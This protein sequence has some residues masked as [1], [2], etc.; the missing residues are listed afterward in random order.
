MA[1]MRK[2]KLQLSNPICSS[3][4]IN[5]G[6]STASTKYW[7]P[8]TIW[9]F[10]SELVLL[11]PN[12]DGLQLF[13]DFVRGCTRQLQKTKTS[14]MHGNDWF[15]LNAKLSII[16]FISWR[17]HILYIKFLIYIDWLI[18]W[19]VDWLVL[20]VDVVDYNMFQWKIGNRWNA[21]R[22]FLLI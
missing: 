8:S 7:P 2:K 22:S 15:L 11:P 17:E 9:R 20:N 3:C 16:S 14:W 1:T 18:D 13:E 21:F 19:L 4:D 12:T 6:I 10:L 5:F